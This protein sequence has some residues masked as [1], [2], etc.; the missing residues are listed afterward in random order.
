M[1]HPNIARQY[2]NEIYD[3]APKFLRPGR[4]AVIKEGVN[5]DWLL[6]QSRIAKYDTDRSHF[7]TRQLSSIQEVTCLPSQSIAFFG[8]VLPRLVFFVMGRPRAS[9]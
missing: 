8:L 4:H 1:S 7:Q 3:E 2:R 9:V 5:S 6:A